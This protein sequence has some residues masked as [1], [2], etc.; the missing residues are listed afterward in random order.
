MHFYPLFTL[1]TA[2]SC[3]A[4]LIPFNHQLL[5]RGRSYT[6]DPVAKGEAPFQVEIMSRDG[7][8]LVCGGTLIS[9]TAVLT[10]AECVKDSK[11]KDLLVRAGSQRYKPSSKRIAHSITANIV[12]VKPAPGG[13]D[14]ILVLS[15]AIEESKSMDIGYARFGPANFDP[16]PGESIFGWSKLRLS[17]SNHPSDPH[18]TPDGPL[19]QI[20]HYKFKD[21]RKKLGLETL[22]VTG[23]RYPH[24]RLLVEDRGSPLV[25][26]KGEFVGMLTTKRWKEYDFDS[27]ILGAVRVGPLMKWIQTE[28][29]DLPE[30]NDPPSWRESLIPS[31]SRHQGREYARVG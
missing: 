22:T 10:L 29:K 15:P 9:P 16:Q 14:V 6:F 25:N 17:H 8:Q 2:A 26:K 7:H 3:A 1:A 31:S 13:G 12:Q 23:E 27:E 5:P 24:G 18:K 21:W 19:L 30:K 4:S 20:S 11:H 28:V